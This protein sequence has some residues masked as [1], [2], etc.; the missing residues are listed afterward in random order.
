MT[1]TIQTRRKFTIDQANKNEG[2]RFIS[3]PFSI[4]N[5][6]LEVAHDTN[7]VYKIMTTNNFDSIREFLTRESYKEVAAFYRDVKNSGKVQKLYWFM[8]RES[9]P[10]WGEQ[11]EAVAFLKNEILLN[12]SYYR[13]KRIREEFLKWH[14]RARRKQ[15]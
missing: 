7:L 10:N 5:Q 12:F 9:N 14:P 8:D 2:C 4:I 3:V 11:E 1:T 13:E 6:I 15:A